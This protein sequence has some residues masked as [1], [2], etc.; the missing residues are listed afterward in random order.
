MKSKKWMVIAIAMLI[1]VLHHHTHINYNQ[2]QI[3]KRRIQPVQ[4]TKSDFFLL[5]GFLPVAL[6]W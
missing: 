1:L 4:E 3:R 2:T 6:G 5:P